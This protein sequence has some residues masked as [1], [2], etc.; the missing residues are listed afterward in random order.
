MHAL[1]VHVSRYMRICDDA[2]EAVCSAIEHYTRIGPRRQ[3]LSGAIKRARRPLQCLIDKAREPLIESGT[4][5][6]RDKGRGLT[7]NRGEYWGTPRPPRLTIPG[8][9]PLF[10]PEVIS[11]GKA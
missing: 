5:R 3:R 4:H 8:A 1:T 7:G 9:A 10:R 2:I 6:R 11:R